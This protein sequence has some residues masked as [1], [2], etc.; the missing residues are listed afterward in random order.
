[1][2]KDMLYFYLQKGEKVMKDKEAYSVSSVD[3][4]MVENI[5]SYTAEVWNIKFL[6]SPFILFFSI[7]N[8][9]KV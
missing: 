4:K 2:S 7:K 9:K 3:L 1:M 6:F 5:K 8:I